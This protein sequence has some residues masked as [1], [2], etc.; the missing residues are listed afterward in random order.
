MKTTNEFI[1]DLGRYYFDFTACT[2]K[3]GYAQV[4]TCQDASYFGMWANPD[5]LVIV[6]YIEGDI[7]TKEAA[8]EREFVDELLYTK[9][10]NEDNGF[11]F[12]GIDPGFNE[13]LKQRFVNIGLGELLH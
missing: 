12:L 9:K 10:W 11:R 2:T 1:S 13:E 5:K 8:N 6:A 3:K 4:D 7:I